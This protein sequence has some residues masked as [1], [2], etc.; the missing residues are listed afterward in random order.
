ML[1]RRST[2]QSIAWF[3]D[4]HHA[5]QLDLDPPYQRLSVWN[6]NYRQF[7]IDTILKNY[8]SPAVF[9]DV[10]IAA[11]GR[12]VYHVVDGKQRL[13]T[14]VEYVQDAFRTADG[15]SDKEVEGKYFSQLPD[16]Q[17]NR[18][19]RYLVPVEFLDNANEAELEE[20]FDRLNRNV[21]KLNAQELRNARYSGEFI[22]LMR[23]L[24][25]DPFWADI[26]LAT[27]SRIRRMLDIE[28]VSEIFLLTMEGIQE[29]KGRLDEVYSEYDSELPDIEA[30]RR[31]YESCKS[32]VSNLWPHLTSKRFE[33]LADFYSLW[34]ACLNVLREQKTLDILETATNISKFADSVD[35][36]RVTVRDADLGNLAPDTS[37]D[38]DAQRYLVASTQ[39]SSK[40]PNRRLRAEL[41]QKHFV[42][43]KA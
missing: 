5:R 40:A 16:N 3:L 26:G 12:T 38:R 10:E 6:K 27:K 28:Y 24:A 43:E 18:F 42:Y 19:L 33:N 34:A 1:E 41:L 25:D 2:A 7:F 29:G 31:T 14:I 4:L 9:L 13:T 32:L 23:N 11:G 21:A 17:Q 30:H 22:S 39:G 8:P 35:S 37:T 15:H 36:L 20:A